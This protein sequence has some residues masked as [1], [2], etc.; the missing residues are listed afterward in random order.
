VDGIA[1]HVPGAVLARGQAGE[2]HGG[3]RQCDEDERFAG[4]VGE[5]AHDSAV[6]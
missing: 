4:V 6:G 3:Q 5:R 1:P 2:M